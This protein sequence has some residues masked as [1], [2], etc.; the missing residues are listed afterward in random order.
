VPGKRKQPDALAALLKAAPSRTVKEL[1][2]KLAATRPDIRRECF[3]YLKK[4]APLSARQ[5]KQSEGE[6]LLALWSELDPDLEELDECGGR[7]YGTGDHVGTLLY[8]IKQKLSGKNRIEARFRHDLLDYVLPYI[9]SGN[10]GLDDELYDVAYATCHDNHDL[11]ALAEAFERMS[12]DWKT[13]HARR[14]YRKLGDR[15]KYL[16]L[17]NRK[18]IY[19]VDY[20][21]LAGFYWESGEKEKAMQVAEDGLRKAQGRMDELRQFVAQRLKTTGNRKRYLELQFAHATDHLTCDKY[22]AFHKLC[23]RTEWREYETKILARLNNAW[24]TE[25]LRIHM[26][27]KEYEAAVAVLAN[28]RYPLCAWDNDYQV[29]TAKRLEGRFPEEILKYYLSG[30]GNMKANAVR[31]DYAR[32]AKVMAK[33]QRL[34]VEVLDDMARWRVFAVKIKQDNLKRS[35]FQEEF[36]NAVPG[37]RE[38]K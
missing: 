1:L 33:I 21:D 7:D 31:Q 13:E 28:G 38:L 27:R 16:E 35:A 15:D 8:E 24:D 22:K 29:Q 5:Q 6:V 26:H 18:M 17:R 11:R 30:L 23:T 9:E 20:H 36:A 3:E 19:G 2:V 25:R 10:A 4:H 32:K 14:I 37:W 34:L 12:G